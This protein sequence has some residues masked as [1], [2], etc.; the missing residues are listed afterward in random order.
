MIKSKGFGILGFENPKVLISTMPNYNYR[1]M[2][3]K[4]T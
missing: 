1:P 4:I 2:F 3:P